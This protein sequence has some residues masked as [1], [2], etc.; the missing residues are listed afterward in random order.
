MIA[1]SAPTTRRGPKPQRIGLGVFIVLGLLM[2]RVVATLDWDPTLLAAFG[3]DSPDTLA[4]AERELGSV[5]TRA[6][7]GHDGKFFFIQANDPWFADPS[8]HAA[9]LDRP[10]YRAQRMLY[11]TIASGFGL[12]GGMPLVWSM[13]IVNVIGLAV[14]SAVTAVV[15][16]RMGGSTWWGLAFG[17]NVGLVAE[18]LVGGAGILAA[19]LLMVAVAYAQRGGLL[20]AT[21]SMVGAVLSREVLL[22]AAAGVGWWLWRRAQ[23]RAAMLMAGM[24]LV[25]AAVWALFLRARLGWSTGV[26]EIEEFGLPFVGFLRAIPNW[27]PGSISMFVGPAVMV[28][29]VLAVRRTI[30][31]GWLVGWATVGFAPLTLLFTQQVWLSYIDITRAVAPVITAFGLMAFAGRSREYEGILEAPL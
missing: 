31:G 3:S 7:Q 14:G 1:T 16:G 2:L 18:L 19:L 5:A 11:P 6:G 27:E 9:Y 29:L 30:R 13:L 23:Q 24:P 28:L 21:G 12:I 17:A 20:V 15:A 25:A 10:L 8:Q 26:E 4:Y 22:L